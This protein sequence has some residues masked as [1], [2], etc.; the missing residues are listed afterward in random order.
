MFEDFF[1]KLDDLTEWLAGQPTAGA[2]L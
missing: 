1:H 2:G